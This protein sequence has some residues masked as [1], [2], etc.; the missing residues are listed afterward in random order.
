LE[1]IIEKG[2]GKGR[3][4]KSVDE[5]VKKVLI[6]SMIKRGKL[7]KSLYRGVGYMERIK[8][9]KYFIG[10]EEIRII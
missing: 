1:K 10:K 8:K 2:E 9:D 6:T 5:R 7:K 4:K 3:R